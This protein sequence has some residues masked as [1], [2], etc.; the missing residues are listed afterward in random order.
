[1]NGTLPK[2]SIAPKFLIE[3]ALAAELLATEAKRQLYDS[4]GVVFDRVHLQGTATGVTADAFTLTDASGSV[5]VDLGPPGR[6]RPAALAEV[7]EGGRVVVVGALFAPPAP[8]ARRVLA[9]KVAAGVGG[10][11]QWALQVAELAAFVYPAVA[12]EQAPLR[13]ALAGP[14]AA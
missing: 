4:R 3:R 9:H 14:A 2:D 13:R 7:P 6:R 12:A 1:M 8:E 10:A 11:E 5:E